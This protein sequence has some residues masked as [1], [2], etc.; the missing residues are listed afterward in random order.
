MRALALL[1]SIALALAMLQPAEARQDS[2]VEA[3][4]PFRIWVGTLNGLVSETSESSRLPIH[5]PFAGSDQSSSINGY[6]EA[7]L[8][9]GGLLFTVKAESNNRYASQLYVILK[10]PL[11][12]ANVRHERVPVHLKVT[13]SRVG[14]FTFRILTNGNIRGYTS[15]YLNVGVM[16][17]EQFTLRVGL[18]DALKRTLF[19]PSFPG[20][21]IKINDSQFVATFTLK[22]GADHFEAT[23]RISIEEPSIP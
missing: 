13:P 21:T 1:G 11:R 9:R 23:G 19:M 4:G 12:M 10:G 17:L 16:Q 14:D 22:R 3:A 8:D 5:F 6:A 2:V 15:S 20:D 18:K 7:M